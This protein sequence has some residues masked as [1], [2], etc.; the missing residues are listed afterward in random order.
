MRKCCGSALQPAPSFADSAVAAKAVVTGGDLVRAALAEISEADGGAGHGVA[1]TYA[2]ALLEGL[3][4][5]A[6]GDLPA[7]ARMAVHVVAYVLE[8]RRIFDDGFEPN[9]E[10]ADPV[11]V[12]RLLDSCFADAGLVH[13]GGDVASGPGWGRSVVAHICAHDSDLS[14]SPGGTDAPRAFFYWLLGQERTTRDIRV[15]LRDYAA[16]P[17]DD[18]ARTAARAAAMGPRRFEKFQAMVRSFRS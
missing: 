2:H 10:V 7:R 12:Q 14:G 4:R 13:P 11:A 17:E 15:L 9:L 3:S 6:P 16:L 18:A 1:K 5:L 8:N